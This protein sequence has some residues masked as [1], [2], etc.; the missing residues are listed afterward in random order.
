MNGGRQRVV[1][2]ESQVIAGVLVVFQAEAVFADPH[3]EECEF[4]SH[5]A[6]LKL[7]SPPQ[8]HL[9]A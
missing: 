1:K 3:S 4:F 5:I 6:V 2:H 9:M 7:L 8:Q